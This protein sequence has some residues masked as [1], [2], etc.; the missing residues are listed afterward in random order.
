MALRLRDD[1]HWCKSGAKIVFLDLERG[2]YFSL[3]QAPSD[4]FLRLVGGTEQPTDQRLFEILI[5]RGMLV[6][7]ED[8]SSIQSPPSI[9]PP[10]C[11]YHFEPFPRAKLIDLIR[12]LASELRSAWAL[13]RQAIRKVIRSAQYRPSRRDHAPGDQPGS[14]NAI[15]AGAR[16]C[17]FISRA[18]DRCL[19]RALAVK[20]LCNRSG[21][22][23]KLVF[24]VI[25]NP[26]S[27]HCWVQ[28]E[29]SVLVGG[30]EQ[31]RLFTPILVVE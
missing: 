29:A 21:V 15:V 13:R 2:R 24:G 3:P 26:F 14:L 23:A 22:K 19:T 10:M 20:S 4:A 30:F 25:A 9:D 8:C 11:D 6:E 31:A 16:S 18:H 17:A 5:R 7:D 27:A 12:E 28:L 1:L